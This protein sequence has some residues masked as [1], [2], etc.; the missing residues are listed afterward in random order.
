MDN[1]TDKN[2][3]HRL[4]RLAVKMNVPSIIL[5]TDLTTLSTTYTVHFTIFLNFFKKF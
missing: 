4:L 2:D 5:S 1:I 3:I